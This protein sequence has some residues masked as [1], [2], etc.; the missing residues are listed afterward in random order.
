M[1]ASWIKIECSL[2]RKREVRVIARR[3]GVEED[4]VLG[5]LVRFWSWVR[6]NSDDGVIPLYTAED[7]D[8][9]VQMEGFADAMAEAGWLELASAA[10]TVPKYDRHNSAKARS[11]AANATRMRQK[12]KDSGGK[13]EDASARVIQQVMEHAE[14]N[15]EQ[16]H[17]LREWVAYLPRVGKRP[18]AVQI[19][20]QL[21]ELRRTRRLGKFAEIVDA[22]IRLGKNVLY[23]DVLDRGQQAGGHKMYQPRSD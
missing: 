4:L 5:K 16:E 22:C 15:G 3:L 10:A 6:E 7:I 20:L 12:R 21:D 17:A 8:Y 1:P 18:D 13:S 23:T 14:M 11:R 9:E 2:P 19:C